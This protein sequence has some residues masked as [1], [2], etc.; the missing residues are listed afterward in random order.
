MKRFSDWTAF[1]AAV[2]AANCGGDLHWTLADGSPSRN[3]PG[4]SQVTGCTCE[5]AWLAIEEQSPVRVSAL[6][7]SPRFPAASSE[8]VQWV[9]S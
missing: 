9:V 1:F 5:S 3:V 7:V 4:D 2:K 6:P 8:A